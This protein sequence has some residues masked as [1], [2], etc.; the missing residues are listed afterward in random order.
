MSN[1]TDHYVILDRSDPHAAQWVLLVRV[2]RA[3]WRSASAQIPATI[4]ALLDGIGQPVADEQARL[5]L[6]ITVA[7][8]RLIVLRPLP[9][10]G[11][12]YRVDTPDDEGVER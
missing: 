3:G 2:D 10:S 5:V 4:P 11:H 12:V 9:G 7:L 8:D 1:P 6:W